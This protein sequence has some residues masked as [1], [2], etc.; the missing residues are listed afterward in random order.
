MIKASFTLKFKNKN[1]Y[2]CSKF[3]HFIGA[4]HEVKK[5]KKK[6]FK[7]CNITFTKD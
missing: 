3:V 1:N 5:K 7:K 2:S 4:E 6:A